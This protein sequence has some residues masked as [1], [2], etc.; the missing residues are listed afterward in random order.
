MI[1]KR[2]FPLLLAGVTLLLWV[3]PV[4]ATTWINTDDEPRLAFLAVEW[5]KTD[6]YR[7]EW[8]LWDIMSSGGPVGHGVDYPTSSYLDSEIWAMGLYLPGQGFTYGARA[9]RICGDAGRHARDRV[10]GA[11][12]SAG[13]PR[14]R[15]A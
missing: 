2:K 10:A 5:T 12:R 14:P 7:H 13:A 8:W 11:Q 9:D 3:L 6:H 4:K 1:S 15:G